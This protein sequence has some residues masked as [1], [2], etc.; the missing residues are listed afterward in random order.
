MIVVYWIPGHLGAAV[1]LQLC[2]HRRAGEEL[3]ARAA[4]G[5]DEVEERLG[6]PELHAGR[7]QA[8][9][10]PYRVVPLYSGAKA[11]YLATLLAPPRYLSQYS[12][13]NVPSEWPTRSTLDG[14]GGGEHAV[15]E[16]AELDRRLLDRDHAAEVRE[17]GI[18]AVGQREHAVA[19]LGQQRRD[20]AT[21]SR[22]S[23]RRARGRARLGR[24]A[25]PRACSSSCWRPSA[26]WPG[27]SARPRG[28]PPRARAPRTR[29][30]PR[31]KLLRI[32]TSLPDAD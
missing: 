15:D 31:S 2:H 21:S 13:M 3:I 24:G 19:A 4:E 30:L 22:P 29:P 9:P 25:P 23:S 26:G 10:A 32:G 1:G 28:P 12:G 11:T 20:V 5:A 27:W 17:A 6:E 14:A 7:G 18:E 8:A 16:R